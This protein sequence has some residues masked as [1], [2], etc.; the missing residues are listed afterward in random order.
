MSEE[1]FQ[2]LVTPILEN[3]LWIL[4]TGFLHVVLSTRYPAFSN[5]VISN[6]K[7]AL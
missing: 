6:P 2:T 1:F 3:I 5:C 7:K 4:F